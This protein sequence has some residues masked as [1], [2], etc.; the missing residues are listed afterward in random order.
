MEWLAI[1][2]IIPDSTLLGDR[3]GKYLVLL[4]PSL[5]SILACT[6]PSHLPS[7]HWWKSVFEGA[8]VTYSKPWKKPEMA[9]FTQKIPLCFRLKNFITAFITNIVHI[10]QYRTCSCQS[11]WHATRWP[12][13]VKSTPWGRIN[14]AAN[15]HHS[16]INARFQISKKQCWDLSACFKIL[17]LEAT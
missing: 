1:F 13:S 6:N 9:I 12:T 2:V 5:I 11:D 17:K 16:Q 4:I 15:C 8:G 7:Q 3:H 10:S 14:M